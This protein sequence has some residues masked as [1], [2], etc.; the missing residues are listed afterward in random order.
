[1]A[2]NNDSIAIDIEPWFIPIDIFK[3]SC[4]IIAIIL[5]LIFLHIILFEKSCHTVPMLLVSNSYLAQLIY[6]ID[7]LLIALFTLQND[8]KQNQFGYSFCILGG[9]ISYAITM[10]QMYSYLLQA[11]YR[12]ITV[13]YPSRLFWQSVRLQTILI[14]ITWI[15]G[16]IYIIVLIFTNQ[17]IYLIDDQICQMPL[18]LSFLTIF[19]ALY[20]YMFPLGAIMVTYFKMVLYV[21]EMGKRATPANT[22][23]RAQRELRMIHRIVT[24]VLFLMILGVPYVLFILMSFFNSAPKYHFRIAYIFIVISLV[25]MMI[26]LFQIAEPLK[27]SIMKKLRRRPIDIVPTFT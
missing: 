1:M 10:I 22:L 18:R 5:A 11:I 20:I 21:R 25:F 12:Y 23:I 24:L 15:C 17:I 4:A 27:A 2:F 3:I 13:M 7:V 14:I 16:T 19:N 26:A 8:R 6:A 9:S